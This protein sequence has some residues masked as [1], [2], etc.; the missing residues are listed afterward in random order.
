MSTSSSAGT[1]TRCRPPDDGGIGQ[2]AFPQHEARARAHDPVQ[3]AFSPCA[4]SRPGNM[5][6]SVFLTRAGGSSPP[7]APRRS[8]ASPIP[9]TSGS[10]VTSSSMKVCWNAEYPLPAMLAK[11]VARAANRERDRDDPVRPETAFR[12]PAPSKPAGHRR[13]G[14]DARG[15]RLAGHRFVVIGP[16][17]PA[18]GHRPRRSWPRRFIAC[19]PSPRWVWTLVVI[20]SQSSA[21][22]HRPLVIG[23]WSPARGHRP[24]VRRP[25]R[26]WPRRF[27]R[28][29]PGT[30]SPPAAR[31]R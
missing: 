5:S 30:S 14:V 25:R 16:W 11:S 28:T 26:S 9:S 8:R 12:G 29:A 4:P 13:G 19:G 1:H 21:R 7:T 15:H 20:G 18:R 6:R 10:Q 2:R 27:I 23:P 3:G 24:A 17:S 22:G 31:R